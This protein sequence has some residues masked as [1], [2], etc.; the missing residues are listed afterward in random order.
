MET[1]ADSQ[2]P[3]GNPDRLAKTSSALTV[4]KD[5]SYGGHRLAADQ[6]DGVVSGR[7]GETLGLPVGV[8]Q[9]AA[10]FVQQLLVVQRDAGPAAQQLLEQ[11]R[12]VDGQETA[13]VTHSSYGCHWRRG[14]ASSHVLY[15][16]M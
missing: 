3:T 16:W 5:E 8:Q 10:A 7:P 1:K 12:P 11:R 4:F 14:G 9:E 15:S 2:L 6:H 13:V